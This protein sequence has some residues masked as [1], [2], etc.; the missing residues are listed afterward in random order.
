M[1]PSTKQTC[2]W[3]VYLSLYVYSYQPSRPCDFGLAKSFTWP[4]WMTLSIEQACFE[5]CT[6]KISVLCLVASSSESISLQA[7]V[8]LR[9][10]PLGWSR[11]TGATII[12]F[13]WWTARLPLAPRLKPSRSKCRIKHSSSIIIAVASSIERWRSWLPLG[14]L[15]ETAIS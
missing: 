6:E 14:T 4:T 10:W 8:M 13:R 11:I 2:I 1:A 5:Q 7:E 15:T 3:A 12:W 9:T